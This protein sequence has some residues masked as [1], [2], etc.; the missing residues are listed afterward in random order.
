VQNDVYHYD[1]LGNLNDRSWLDNTGASVQEN[2]GYDSLNRLTSSQVGIQG[3]KIYAYDEI[4][5]L[6]SKSGATY[7]YPASGASSVRPHAVASITGTVNGIVNPSFSY[8]NNGNLTAGLGRTIAWMSFNMPSSITQ[9]SVTP[10]IVDSFVYGP[11]HQRAKQVQSTGKTLYYAGAMEKEVLGSMT[12]V[13]TYLPNGIGVLIDNGSTVQTR[14]VHKDHLGSV[15]VITKEDGSPAERMSYEPFGK[16]RNLDGTD[17]PGNALF[18]ATDNK[19][20]TGHE[21]LDN[22]GLI[23]MNGRVYDPSVAQFTA[24]D[25]TVSRPGDGQSFNRYSYVT[26]N[27]LKFTDPTGYAEYITVQ[28]SPTAPNDANKPITTGCLN[29]GCTFAAWVTVT[30][31]NPPDVQPTTT[32]REQVA[33]LVVPITPPVAA[34]TQGINQMGGKNNDPGDQLLQQAGQGR[35]NSGMSGGQLDPNDLDPRERNQPGR[36]ITTNESMSDRAAEYQTQVT[37]RPA[38]QSYIVNGVKFDGYN[39]QALID[40]KGPGYGN[41]VD[42]SGKFETWAQARSDLVMQA[43]RQLDVANGV[44]IQWHVAESQSAAAIRS[45][46]SESNIQG[47]R[48]I[49]TPPGF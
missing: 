3:Q 40:A 23:H 12:T 26:N 28:D 41:F 22:V 43:T 25:P 20:Y 2:F 14:Y 13:K 10:N 35:G 38:N 16:R 8:D 48:I 27:P 15:A 31:V 47:I 33:Q 6:I 42:A 39:G 5:N 30:W 24:A 4:G 7:N 1:S 17:D 44:P 36:W 11:E 18:G 9:T 29:P 21:M 45:L 32:A 19:G 49:Y 37:G 46:F 34:P